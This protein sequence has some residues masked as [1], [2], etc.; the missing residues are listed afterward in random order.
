MNEKNLERL[1]KILADSSDR[2]EQHLL[3]K[4]KDVL[5]RM[6]NNK[7]DTKENKRKS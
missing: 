4:A 2:I 3:L 7:N 6:L 5:S 1:K